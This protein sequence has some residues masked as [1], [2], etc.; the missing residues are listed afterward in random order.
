[1]V[2]AYKIYKMKSSDYAGI[3]RLASNLYPKWFEKGAIE[4][5]IPTDMKLSYG[6]VAKKQDKIV[7]FIIYHSYAGQVQISWLGVSPKMQNRGIGTKLVQRLERELQ[8]IGADSLWVETISSKEKYKPYEQTRKF[9]KKM[10]FKISKHNKITYEQSGATY[11]YY[12]VTLVKTLT[13]S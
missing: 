13:T 3:M 10:G 7:G 8:K 1:V 2:S 9:Y 5:D 12:A 11:Y 4:E 6:F